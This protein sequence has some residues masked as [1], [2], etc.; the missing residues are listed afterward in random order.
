MKG[1]VSSGIAPPITS[2]VGTGM[3][4]KPGAAWV[5]RHLTTRQGSA[6]PPSYSVRA[7]QILR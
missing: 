7:S 6:D 2:L 3:A 1:G 4:Y 5:H